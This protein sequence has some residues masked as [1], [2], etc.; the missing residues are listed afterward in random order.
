M[1]VDCCLKVYL[2]W[3]SF[4]LAGSVKIGCH[5]FLGLSTST[6]FNMGIQIEDFLEIKYNCF[7]EYDRL[8]CFKS[9]QDT[10]LMRK[11]FA[12]KRNP[13]TDALT[14]TIPKEYRPRRH[15]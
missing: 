5:P 3:P 14:V 4:D 12:L 13:K 1:G 11:S 6:P 9:I 15:F 8:Y 2:S 10:S 7:S